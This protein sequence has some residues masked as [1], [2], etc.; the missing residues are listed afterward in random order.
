MQSRTRLQIRTSIGRPLGAIFG[1]A[2]DDGDTS[3]LIDTV[4]LY[5]GDDIHIGKEV[6]ISTINGS[7]V[8]E[9]VRVSDSATGGDCTISPVASGVI[10]EDDVYEM[11]PTPLSRDDV[12]DVIDMA[13]MEATRKVQPKKQTEGHFTLDEILEYSWL[14]G[15]TAVYLLEYCKSIGIEKT[16]NNCEVA[17]DDET[18]GA[19]ALSTLYKVEGSYSNAIT[20]SADAGA[21]EL[22]STDVISSVDL[23]QCD[24]VEIWMRSSVALDAGDMQLHLDNTAACASAL[25]TLDIPAMDANKDYVHVISLANPTSDTAIISCGIYQVCDKGACILYVDHIR[26]YKST[27]REFVT[28]NSQHWD[29]VR[30]SASTIKLT[31]LGLAMVGVGK[32]I[33]ISGY[34]IPTIMTADTDTCTV[35]P[36]FVVY[37]A[38]GHMMLNHA[39][40]R[41]LKINERAELGKVNFGKAEQLLREMSTNWKPGTRFV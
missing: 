34:Q 23:S 15:Y 4:G 9:T 5:G 41:Q 14:S 36:A 37:W 29:V 35:D 33:R 6:Y 21:G 13:I 2:S 3:S 12:N 25:E 24:K 30:G 22:L 31:E 8:T 1:T 38:I 11:W 40:S 10:K 28:L 16:I 19:N 7:A 20:V 32:E 17:W 26:A 39:K 27:S 18:N